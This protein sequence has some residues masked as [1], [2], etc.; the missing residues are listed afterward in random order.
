VELVAGLESTWHMVQDALARWTTADIED[1]VSRPESLT[2]EEKEKRRQR[3]QLENMSSSVQT[4]ADKNDFDTKLKEAGGSLVVVDFYATWCG[5]CKMI[6]PK[7]EE[8]AKVMTDV[9]FLKVDVD[10]CEDIASLYG[11]SCMPTFMFFKNGEKVQ[12]FSGANVEKV[13]EIIN[14]CK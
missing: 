2:E 5:P 12:E 11:I 6:S 9:I 14:T 10:E 7:L 13:K 3:I 4:V 8:M 1:A